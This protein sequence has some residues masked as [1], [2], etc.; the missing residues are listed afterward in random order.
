MTDM[1]EFKQA[2]A[3][4]TGY[5]GW[6]IGNYPLCEKEAKVIAM[7]LETVIARAAKDEKFSQVLGELMKEG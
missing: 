7:A 6:D 1:M 5:T 4:I 2:Y 3:N